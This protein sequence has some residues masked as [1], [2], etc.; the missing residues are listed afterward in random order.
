MQLSIYRNLVQSEV[1]DTSARAQNVIDD[2]IKAVYQEILGY[3]AKYIIGSTEED[4]T[5]SVSNRYIT[6]TNAYT[7]FKKVL[8]H[9]ATDTNFKELN[10]MLEED[11]YA[12]YVNS[13]AGEPTRYYL[14]GNLIYFDLVPSSAGTVK[15]VGVEAQ[16]ELTGSNTSVLPDRFTYVLV[17]GAIAWFKAY[18][19]TPD[20]DSYQKIYKGSYWGQGRIDGLLGKIIQ[21][22]SV[23]REV[24]KPR[25][26]GR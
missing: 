2:G 12:R 18:E 7:E 23:K 20:A 1:G 26:F 5:A 17:A 21:E 24:I 19:G 6:P 11:Y 13:D 4:V 22:L 16:D 25:F 10:P 9:S 14:K 3:I 15:V 8:W